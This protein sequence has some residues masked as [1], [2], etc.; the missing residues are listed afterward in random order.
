[1]STHHYS[2]T[3]EFG[4]FTRSNYLIYY[5]HSKGTQETKSQ[6]LILNVRYNG[7]TVAI[8]QLNICI[9]C[10]VVCLCLLSFQGIFFTENVIGG[11][12]RLKGYSG[13]V[14]RGTPR[15]RHFGRYYAICI[16]CFLCYKPQI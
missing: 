2:D 9:F 11:D 13:G 14:T 16:Y 8:I 4:L 3:I 5:K 7:K 6:Y 15:S 10:V 1:L 12:I